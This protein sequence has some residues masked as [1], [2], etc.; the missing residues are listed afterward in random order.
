MKPQY[1]EKFET[2][3]K[4]LEG[5][6]IITG[7]TLLIEVLA[8]PE[9]KTESGIILAVDPDQ[10]IGGVESNRAKIGYVLGV[11]EGYYDSE[12]GETIPLDVPVG[13]VVIIPTFSMR[14]LSTFPGMASMTSGKLGIISEKEVNFYYRDL[15]TYE[16]ARGIL[17]G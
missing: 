6:A 16:K 8:E 15:E 9:L 10:R 5:S 14:E 2:L 7:D 4:E 3:F 13:A 1:A 17:N 11:G 12:T